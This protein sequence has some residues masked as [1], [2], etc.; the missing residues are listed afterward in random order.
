MKRLEIWG[1]SIPGN[2]ARKKIM[3]MDIGKNPFYLI[4][5]FRMLAALNGSKYKK[6]KKELDTFTYL[7]GI[8]KA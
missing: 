7:A 4:Q 1:A 3:D 2:S 5:M 6:C 8:K